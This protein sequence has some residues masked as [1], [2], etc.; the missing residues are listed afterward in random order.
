[1]S[2]TSSNSI[3]LRLQFFDFLFG[4][5]KGQLCIATG[6]ATKS[7]FRQHWFKWPEQRLELGHFIEDQSAKYNVWFGV[8]LFNRPERKRDFAIPG[9]IVWS[10]LDF[11]KP[12]DL[13]PIPSV[14]I[15]SSPDRYQAIWSLKDV[16]PPDVAQDYSRR[17]A[18]HVGADKS[19]W[20]LEQ[21]L[22]VPFTKNFKYEE[23]QQVKLLRILGTLQDNDYFDRLPEP[24]PTTTGSVEVEELPDNLPDLEHVLYSYKR[25]LNDPTSTNSTVFK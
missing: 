18:Y 17:L 19:G 7:V 21:L 22:R 13:D 9:T 20:D 12:F 3:T 6:N 14:I 11:V 2:T 8:T 25:E 10:D 23:P 15:E 16:V 24:V 5:E 1:M 4:T